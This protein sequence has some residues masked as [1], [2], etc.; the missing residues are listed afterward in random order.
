MHPIPVTRLLL[1]FSGL[2]WAL[3]ARLHWCC[4]CFI[5]VLFDME[6]TKLPHLPSDH[7]AVIFPWLVWLKLCWCSSLG[8]SCAQS[9]FY[10]LKCL[11]WYVFALFLSLLLLCDCI[12]PRDCIRLIIYTHRTCIAPKTLCVY[13]HWTFYSKNM[14]ADNKLEHKFTS[15]TI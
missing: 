9:I 13:T 2:V 15:R 7:Q 11:M 8:R 12:S 3:P 1:S 5:N 6:V 10:G 14:Q 4:K